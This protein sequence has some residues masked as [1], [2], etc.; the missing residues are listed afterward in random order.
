M[1]ILYLGYCNSLG[2]LGISGASLLS[3]R[4]A[5]DLKRGNAQSRLVHTIC[6]LSRS[7]A[8]V[9]RAVLNWHWS[10]FKIFISPQ[11]AVVERLR[12]EDCLNRNYC[13]QFWPLCLQRHS[14]RCMKS[15]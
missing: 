8:E 3:R 9:F 1:R 14:Q 6:Q 5:V 15:V 11:A 2:D 13:A 12:S 7:D 10:K 4:V